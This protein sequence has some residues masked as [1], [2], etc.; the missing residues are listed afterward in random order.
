MVI[1]SIYE[2]NRE[3]IAEVVASSF[4]CLND[5]ATPSYINSLMSFGLRLHSF[6][7]WQRNMYIYYINIEFS[8][9][10]L[11]ENFLNSGLL[12]SM[13]KKP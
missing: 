7:L 1:D 3:G 2:E 6:N 10:F 5:R 13:E 12:S 8:F 4:V 11:F 9:F